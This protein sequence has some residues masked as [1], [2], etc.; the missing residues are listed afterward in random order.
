MIQK[1]I[2]FIPIPIRLCYLSKQNP[3]LSLSYCRNKGLLYAISLLGEYRGAHSRKSAYKRG[4]DFLYHVIN[5]EHRMT[6]VSK[7]EIKRLIYPCNKRRHCLKVPINTIQILEAIVMYIDNPRD[8]VCRSK[9][10][11]MRDYQCNKDNIR[12][13]NCYAYIVKEL[14]SQLFLLRESM[15]EDSELLKITDYI[16]RNEHTPKCY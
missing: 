7:T 8:G 15:E 13:H 12:S 6:H 1:F 14:R 2:K 3:E 16:L 11:A 10:K 5:S 4:I 9:C